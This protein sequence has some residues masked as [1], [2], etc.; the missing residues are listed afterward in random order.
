MC[1]N[2]GLMDSAAYSSGRQFFT[3][4]A[5]GPAIFHS[6]PGPFQASGEASLINGMLPLWGGGSLPRGSFHVSVG[7]TKATCYA[8][9]SPTVCYSSFLFCYHLGKLMRDGDLGK[10]KFHVDFYF[11]EMT[12]ALGALLAGVEWCWHFSTPCCDL[13]LPRHPSLSLC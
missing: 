13:W 9:L 1:G 11:L 2:S 5:K 8:V 12:R 6:G 4:K 3:Q 10:K 7:L